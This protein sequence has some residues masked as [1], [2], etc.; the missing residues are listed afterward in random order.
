MQDVHVF[1]AAFGGADGSVVATDGDGFTR[2]LA[3][4]DRN[5]VKHTDVLRIPRR[6]VL[7]LCR[8]AP[9]G[10]LFA[11]RAPD[12]PFASPTGD[13]TEFDCG[14]DVLTGD[15]FCGCAGFFDCVEMIASGACEE[16]TLECED[17]GCTC[18]F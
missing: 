12:Y 18:D 2:V 4:G 8:E 9:N 11:C 5:P 6:V 1:T 3:V 17:D 14:V 10:S 16:G 13:P 15:S 7:S